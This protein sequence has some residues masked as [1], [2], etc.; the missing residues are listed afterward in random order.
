[1]TPETQAQVARRKGCS[2]KKGQFVARH[3]L[4]V[5]NTLEHRSKHGHQGSTR[6]RE[7]VHAQK[8]K[9]KAEQAEAKAAELGLSRT[10]SQGIKLTLNDQGTGYKYVERFT[11]TSKHMFAAYVRG[12]TKNG[13]SSGCFRGVRRAS[14]MEAAV[15]VISNCSE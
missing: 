8:A 10:S 6:Q 5:A 4:D 1:M 12:I 2:A 3:L 13:V 14:A 15:D 7:V 11:S 9:A